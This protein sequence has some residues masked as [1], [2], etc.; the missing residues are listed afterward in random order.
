M[1]IIGVI[2]S[3]ASGDPDSS[4]YI[5]IIIGMLTIYAVLFYGIILIAGNESSN[6]KK[7]K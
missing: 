4:Y 1:I 6:D 5:F 3:E 2:G 7:K